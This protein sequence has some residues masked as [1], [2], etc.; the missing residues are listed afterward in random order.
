MKRRTFIRNSL[1]AGTAITLSPAFAAMSTS[2]GKK[3]I[4]AGAGITGLCCAYELMKSGHDVTVLEASG[5]FGGHVFTGRDGLSDGL[6]ADFGADHVTKPG[7]EKFFEYADEFKLPAI[8]YPNAEG[9]DAAYDKDKLRMIGGKFY[10]SEQLRD[11]IVLKTLG[12]ND[13]EIQYLAE[14]SFDGLHDLYLR[15]YIDKF[16]NPFQPF[17]V[18]YD[19][20]DHIPIADLYKK[21]GATAT[22]LRFMG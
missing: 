7:Y 19:D 6:Y 2:T 10:S 21:E 16:T 12:F 13:H 9:S 5:R 4:V 20:F 1:T 18:G 11:A 14:S 22:A 3:V 8:P 15:H 17:G